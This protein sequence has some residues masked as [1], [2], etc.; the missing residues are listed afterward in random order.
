MSRRSPYN[1]RYQKD[2]KPSGSTKRSAAS[3]K[4]KRDAEESKPTSRRNATKRAHYSVP[5]TPEYRQARKRWWML[6]G[7][8]VVV[9]IVSLAMTGT[10]LATFLPI[11]EEAVRYTSLGLSWVALG[12]I[13][14]SWWLDLK[15]IRPM[16]K[17]HQAELAGKGSGKKDTEDA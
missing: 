16:I 15:R 14:A 6:L 2:T 9:L 13:G 8:A 7:S 12:L 3:A 4:P 11:S 17:A 10:Q 1:E 5:D